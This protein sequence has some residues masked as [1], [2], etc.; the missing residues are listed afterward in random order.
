MNHDIAHGIGVAIGIIIILVVGI[1]IKKYFYTENRKSILNIL[2][3]ALLFGSILGFLVVGILTE[4]CKQD[5]IGCSLL[6][7]W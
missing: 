4:Y 7:S 5:Q 1:I 6:G 2:V 3:W